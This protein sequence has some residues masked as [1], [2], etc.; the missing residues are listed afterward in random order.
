M[1]EFLDFILSF[2]LFCHFEGSEAPRNP[3][4]KK[5]LLQR[6]F[7]GSAFWFSGDFSPPPADRNDSLVFVILSEGLSK[8]ALWAF[9]KRTGARLPGSK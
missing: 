1:K 4:R 8:G 9:G 7:P 3:L 6:P 2:R 5:L